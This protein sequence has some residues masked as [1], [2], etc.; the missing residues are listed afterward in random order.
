MPPEGW[1][2]GGALRAGEQGVLIINLVQVNKGNHRL[3]N[4]DNQYSTV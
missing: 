4:K 2:A 3:V 1:Q